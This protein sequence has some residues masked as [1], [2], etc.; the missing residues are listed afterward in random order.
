MDC[1][2]PHLSVPLHLPS[3]PKLMSTEAWCL[4]TI[5]SCYP[6]C[7]SA[8]N[9]SQNQ[10]LFQWVG[11][12]Y[13]VAKVLEFHLQH[14]SFHDYSGLISFRMDWFDLLAVQG[15]LKSLLQ[16]YSWKASIFQHS[17][18]FTV[19]LSP[20]YMPTGK[21]IALTIWTFVGKVMALLFNTL[22]TGGRN[23][24]PIQ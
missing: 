11:S 3:L 5:S 22:S 7:P 9:L 21:T 18:F 15:T 2:T 1:S 13:Q 8:F 17:A 19:Q 10:G 23:G 16:H 12:L 20:L 14:Q 24:K 6:P 4:P